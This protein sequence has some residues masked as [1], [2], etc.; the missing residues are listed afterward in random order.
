MVRPIPIDD[1][2]LINLSPW[3]VKQGSF[4]F[5]IFFGKKIWGYVMDGFSDNL[6]L[7]EADISFKL[8]ITPQ[9]PSLHVLV[10]NRDGNG[11]NQHLKKMFQLFLFLLHRNVLS[12]PCSYPAVMIRSRNQ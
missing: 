12:D 4:H 9:I 1:G 3:F 10:E 11:I 7:C 8:T 2:F 5:I 6:I